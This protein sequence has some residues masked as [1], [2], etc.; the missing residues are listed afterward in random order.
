MLHTWSSLLHSPLGSGG[1]RTPDNISLII[2]III[3]ITC[4]HPT[5][6][7]CSVIAPSHQPHH[8]PRRHCLYSP[9]G[10]S[11]YSRRQTLDPSV[12]KIQHHFI[13]YHYHLIICTRLSIIVT[14]ARIRIN[15]GHKLGFL[16]GRP[17]NI[18][19]WRQLLTPFTWTNRG[20]S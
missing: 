2:I 19:K 17:W 9:T 3:I 16:G 13:T 7:P 15:V 4:L 1:S 10:R 12:L 8:S 20:K 18:L 6:P 14:E 5:S 11:P